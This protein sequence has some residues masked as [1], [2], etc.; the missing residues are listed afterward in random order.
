MG[1]DR[2]KDKDIEIPELKKRCPYCGEPLEDITFCGKCGKYLGNKDGYHP[3]KESKA[4]I[5]RI[6]IGVIAVAVF[7]FMYLALRK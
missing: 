5:I 3:I 7:L 4:R 2:D 6:A 1:K